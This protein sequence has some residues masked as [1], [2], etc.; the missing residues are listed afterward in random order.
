MT[1]QAHGRQVDHV[2]EARGEDKLRPVP[3][4][5]GQFLERLEES[6]DVE[7]GRISTHG[8]EL[9]VSTSVLADLG[10][11]DVEY[12]PAILISFA[13]VQERGRRTWHPLR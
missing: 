6:A 13:N 12:V 11:V 3:N 9:G 8:N 5:G 2:V 1:D 7:R 4:G 10:T